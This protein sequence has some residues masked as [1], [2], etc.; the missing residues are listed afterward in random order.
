M[1]DDGSSGITAFIE[2]DSKDDA[3]TALTKDR[4]KLQVRMVNLKCDPP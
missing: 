3:Q 2:F 4:K 1:S